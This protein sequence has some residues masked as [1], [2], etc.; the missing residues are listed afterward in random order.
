MP[1][2]PLRTLLL[3]LTF[4]MTAC[5]STP[6][7]GDTPFPAPAPMPDPA[8]STGGSSIGSFVSSG[9]TGLD[10]WRDQ[11]ASRAY[12]EGHTISVIRSVLEDIEPMS[13]FLE[14]SSGAVDQAEFSKPIWEYVDDTV[15]NSRLSN[16]RQRVAN[17]QTLFAALE[18]AYGVQ[19]EYLAAIW[20]METSYG[21]VIGNFDAPSALASMAAEGRRQSFAE[22]ELMA[23]MTILE[24]GDA[25]RHELIAGWAGAMGQTQFM[26]T[27]YVA[28]AVDWTGDGTKDVWRA[29]ADA[30]AS[31]ANYLNASGWRAGEPSLVEVLLPV[32]FQFSLANGVERPTEFW[33]QLGVVPVS[34]ESIDPANIGEAELW[35]PA[36]ATGP[37][38]LLYPNF[39][40]IK[41]Y[42]R[43]DSYALSVS[44]IAEG[45]SGRPAPGG[46]W[47][48][49]ID[50]LSISEIRDLQA[51]LNR[52]GYNAGAVDG[53]AGRGTRSALQRFQIDRGMMADGFPTRTALSHV[54][55]AS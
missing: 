2:L 41:T 25:Y 30:L 35:L 17:D 53:I 10:A 51:G 24:N 34:R 48:R 6:Q 40:V 11:F 29:R 20:G 8:P 18:T 12:R 44:L 14:R 46:A 27:T 1:G 21:A 33:R 47:P 3:T 54:L 4:A 26:P 15:S 50:R 37:A 45:I 19:P 13:V 43:A 9:H 52:L 36:G 22:R 5:E 49:D 42:N 7:T 38:F 16:G 32:N 28:Y 55:A 39:N 31:A 23:L